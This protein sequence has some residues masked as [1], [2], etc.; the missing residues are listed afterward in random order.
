[1]D[2]PQGNTRTIAQ[3]ALHSVHKADK[4]VVPVD[5]VAVQAVAAVTSEGEE[6]IAASMVIAP[7]RQWHHSIIT[8]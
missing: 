1:M 6:E 7:Q 4:V 2:K 8:T 5:L 3:L